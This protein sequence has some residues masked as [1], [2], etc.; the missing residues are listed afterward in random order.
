MRI[1]ME[2]SFH[3]RKNTFQTENLP[4]DRT[5]PNSL[6]ASSGSTKLVG[7]HLPCNE[8]SQT[9]H[10]E[11]GA[12][13]K[14]CRMNSKL[15]GNQAS[16]SAGYRLVPRVDVGLVTRSSTAVPSPDVQVR[17]F[18]RE[19]SGNCSAGRSTASSDFLTRLAQ[20]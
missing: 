7:W 16:C 5:T 8:V 15:P 12:L 20:S 4:E 17:A 10:R 1:G 3:T 14:P 2:S 13:K 11:R 6:E 9:P 18:R 19:M